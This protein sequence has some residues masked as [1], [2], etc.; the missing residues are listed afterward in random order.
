MVASIVMTLFAGAS[1]AEQ[2]NISQLE[3]K[4]LNNITDVNSSFSNTEN[5]VN[6]NASKSVDT[7]AK[8]A[9]DL[10][11][12]IPDSKIVEKDDTYIEKTPQVFASTQT[13]STTMKTIQTVNGHID[14][15]IEKNAEKSNSKKGDG[16]RYSL[17]RDK[18]NMSD[19][20]IVNPDRRTFVKL[21]RNF[22]NRIQ[23]VDNDL[24]TIVIPADKGLDH[25]VQPSDI[26]IQGKADS[27][28]SFIAEM[29]ITCGNKIF[30]LNGAIDSELP[31]QKIRLELDKDSNLT[32]LRENN[33]EAIKK[34]ESL[35][36]EEKLVKIL[37]RVY[38]KDYMKF[39]VV[40]DRYND[41]LN[42]TYTKKITT[43]ISGVIVR[44]FYANR[45]IMQDE[46]LVEMINSGLFV[47][48]NILAVGNVYSSNADSSKLFVI[49]EEIGNEG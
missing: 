38:E 10:I 45:R 47:G 49:S 30:E 20:Q 26:F 22:M 44:E 2:A 5:T 35:P 39:W 7:S 28:S 19:E 11:V 4:L 16:D 36:Y 37:K 17:I 14:K 40:E 23:C 6:S 27:P 1:Y 12:K 46:K 48:E 41:V 9:T 42:M 25:S 21:S 15:K 31:S 13:T 29:Y 32:N 18:V 43:S 34:A 33:L 8:K 3:Q 24:G